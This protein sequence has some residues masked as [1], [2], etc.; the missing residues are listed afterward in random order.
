MAPIPDGDRQAAILDE[1]LRLHDRGLWVVVC[2]GKVPVEP[3]TGWQTRRRSQGE[4]KAA[5]T[6]GHH[7]T[8]I[9]IVL[10]QCPWMDVEADTPE[11]ETFVGDDHDRSDG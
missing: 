5:L 1:A 10:G 9:G 4:L 11:A 8:G 2:S 3:S 6:N 7:A